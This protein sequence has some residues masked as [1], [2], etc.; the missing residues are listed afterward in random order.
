MN[1]NQPQTNCGGGGGAGGGGGSGTPPS[2]GGGG[3]GNGPIVGSFGGG[4]GP[5]VPQVLGE[6]TSTCYYLHDYLRKDFNNNPVEVRKLQVFLRDFEGHTDLQITEVYDD[7]TIKALDEFQ[8]KYKDD[9]LTPWGHTAPTDYTY[10]LTK[11]K[12]NE[13]YCKMAFPVNA[14]QQAEID[15]HRALF[16]YLKEHGGS[17]NN[18]GSVNPNNGGE[19]NPSGDNTVGANSGSNPGSSSLSTLAGVSST[20]QRIVSNMTANVISSGKKV[21]SM[22]LALMA[23]PFGSLFGGIY[24]KMSPD[25]A[26]SYGV[27]G[28]INIILVII[29]IVMSYLWY[30]ERKN[31]KKIEALNEEIDL[32]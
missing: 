18:P 25:G 23:W 1:V 29:I 7:Q 14:A 4:N 20:T 27:L 17:S 8:W 3:G 2:S 31:N 11:K 26:A 22:A 10:I 12:V 32:K 30:R 5:I 24:G 9:V 15:A 28:L 21:G 19:N 13:I 6:S 16:E